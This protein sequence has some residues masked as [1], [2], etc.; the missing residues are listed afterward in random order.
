M[1]SPTKVYEFTDNGMV[2]LDPGEENVSRD[3]NRWAYCV[4]APTTGI[5]KKGDIVIDSAGTH[6][7]FC[8]VSGSPGTWVAA[9]GA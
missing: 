8:T 3:R 4:G 9:A 2:Q 1:A 7:R 6:I 5:W